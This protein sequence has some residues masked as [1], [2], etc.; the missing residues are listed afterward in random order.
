M[1]TD[2]GLTIKRC[3]PF[4]DDMNTG[5]IIPP[6]ATVRL[7]VR[8]GGSTVEAGWD[9]DR[10]MVSVHGDHQ[11]KG[12]PKTPRAACKFH[13][14]WTILNRRDGIGRM[15]TLIAEPD[16]LWALTVWGVAVL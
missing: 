11:V 10:T 4:L 7:D 5:W 3:M 15:P 14:P 9:F 16:R 6:A 1:T 2:K 13:N 8:G 12:N